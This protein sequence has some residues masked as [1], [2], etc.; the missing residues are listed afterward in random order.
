MTN[1]TLFVAA[2]A[3]VLLLGAAYTPASAAD[4]DV[5]A[6]AGIV[7]AADDSAEDDSADDDGS[8]KMGQGEGTQSGDEATTP[9]N[10][11]QKIDQPARRN[12]TTGNE[13]DDEDDVMPPPE[14]EDVPP[15]DG[16]N[17]E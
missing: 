9:E 1:S 11:S 13:S 7:L 14:D 12:P 4:R 17:P 15:E 8:A 10:D 3:A 2:S 5:T 16:E 6:I